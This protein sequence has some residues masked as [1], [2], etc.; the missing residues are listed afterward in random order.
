MAAE[1]DPIRPEVLP[2]CDKPQ[3]L[4]NVDAVKNAALFFLAGLVLGFIGA[5]FYRRS[6]RR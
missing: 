1:T 6:N 2:V 5:E 3:M 4:L